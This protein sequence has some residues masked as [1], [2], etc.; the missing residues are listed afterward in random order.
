[1]NTAHISTPQKFAFIGIDNTSI[2]M[3][4]CWNIET[5]A[6]SSCI[7]TEHLTSTVTV[8]TTY[9]ASPSS[10]VG[11]GLPVA[12]VFATITAIVTTT[13]A[14]LMGGLLYRRHTRK[15]PAQN[16]SSEQSMYIYNTHLKRYNFENF[17]SI[18]PY[19]SNL[20]CI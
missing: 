17:S 8:V 4:M 7:N 15:R 18:I 5:V 19:R 14:I 1:M 3:L 13:V 9:A 10:G 16:G 12:V 11:A 2:Y 20:K 6:P